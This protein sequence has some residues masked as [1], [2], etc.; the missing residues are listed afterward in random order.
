MSD[1]LIGQYLRIECPGLKDIGADYP[2]A[3]A[4]VYVWDDSA[5]PQESIQIDW[6]D[7]NI[8]KP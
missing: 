8:P 5:P 2:I 6:N 1:S 4:K 3:Y 7:P